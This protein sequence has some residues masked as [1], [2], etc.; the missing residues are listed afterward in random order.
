MPK[1]VG[2]I[3][4]RM[5]SSRLPGKVL[6]D[7]GGK[8]M[9]EWV[10]SRLQRARTVDEII[11]ATTTD[12]TD[13]AIV[14]WCQGKQIPH[15]RGSLHDVLDRFYQAARRYD[16]EVIVRV[17][18][19]CPLLDP[20]LVDETV[21]AFNGLDAAPGQFD[22]AANRL[23]PPFHRTYPIGLDT[24]VCTFAALERAWREAAQPFHREHVMPYFYEGIETPQRFEKL[25]VPGF[26][27]VYESPRGFRVL[28]LNHAQDFG[29]LRWTVDTPVDLAVLERIAMHLSGRMD[30]TW[31]DILA[32]VQQEPDLMKL[33]A[34]TY[35][36]DF[37]ESEQ[38]PAW[39]T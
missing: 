25:H 12:Q 37:R 35:H 34:G 39:N 24:E 18:A 11:V 32:I 5:T 14:Q 31:Q 7:L 22:F 33:N 29:E 26:L 21:Q 2:I 38:G 10:V 19:D 3:Q 23:P 8:P 28:L 27:D 20:V 30:F 15:S 4:A 16:A 6:R 1:T 13:E 9:L 17:T 36:K